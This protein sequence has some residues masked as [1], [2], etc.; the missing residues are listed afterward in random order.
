MD[1]VGI[2]YDTDCDGTS[3]AYHDL[4]HARMID[5]GYD[6]RTYDAVIDRRAFMCD[7]WPT[8][9]AFSRRYWLSDGYYSDSSGIRNCE[10]SSP[11]RP[12]TA[13]LLVNIPTL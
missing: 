5:N 10:I 4:S 11:V 8:L 1:T 3:I 6:E 9:D 13:D 7:I 2:D 12:E